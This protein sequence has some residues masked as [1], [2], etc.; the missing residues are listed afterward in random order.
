MYICRE[1]NNE[2]HVTFSCAVNEKYSD[3]HCNNYVIGEYIYFTFK[4]KDKYYAIY[5]FNKQCVAI[6]AF[7]NDVILE[8][9]PYKKNV[10]IEI[11]STYLLEKMVVTNDATIT[12]NL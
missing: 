2:S 12:L 5:D 1:Y 7:D 4:T 8:V 3:D 10:A 9:R 6:M 11:S